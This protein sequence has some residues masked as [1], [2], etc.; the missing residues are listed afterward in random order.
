MEEI[1]TKAVRSM[2]DQG[3]EFC[4][5]RHQMIDRTFIV[6]VDGGVERSTTEN[7]RG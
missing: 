1:L 7:W 4:D 6:M 5:A 3:A 2:E